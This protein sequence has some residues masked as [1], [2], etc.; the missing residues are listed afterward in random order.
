MFSMIFDS[1]QSL[2]KEELDAW[3]KLDKTK[4]MERCVVVFC[5]FM[6][7]DEVLESRN[8]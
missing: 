7:A 8:V 5:E 2:S 1:L 3:L 6:C 4:S